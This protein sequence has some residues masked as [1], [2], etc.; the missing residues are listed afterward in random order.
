VSA[1]TFSGGGPSKAT[2]MDIEFL[3]IPKLERTG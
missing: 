3:Q 1:V 2:S